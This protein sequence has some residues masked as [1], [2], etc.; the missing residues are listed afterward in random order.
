MHNWRRR[1][2]I[3]GSSSQRP[4]L[5]AEWTAAIGMRRGRSCRAF[6]RSW[7]RRACLRRG[8]LLTWR[9]R[10]GPGPLSRVGTRADAQTGPCCLERMGAALDAGCFRSAS[11]NPSPGS[12]PS[13]AGSRR[14][15]SHPSHLG[16]AHSH[17]SH[18]GGRAPARAHTQPLEMCAAPPQIHPFQSS[19]ERRMAPW[20]GRFP[21][22]FK[23]AALQGC[24]ARIDTGTTLQTSQS[25]SKM[26]SFRPTATAVA[27]R[28]PQGDPHQRAAPSP[29]GGCASAC[30]H[31]GPSRRACSGI[32]IQRTGDAPTADSSPGFRPGYSRP[33]RVEPARGMTGPS[34]A[35]PRHGRPEL[36]RASTHAHHSCGRRFRS[37]LMRPAHLAA[38]PPSAP[39]TSHGQEP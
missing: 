3:K 8:C 16:R 9:A 24:G 1:E 15:H 14:A 35:G 4:P 2:P 19:Q 36:M 32:L 30:Q 37:A 39:H 22:C 29:N 20:T 6:K 34:R 7:R 25:E 31:S 5:V 38:H 26:T 33:A 23:V 12:L 27:L 10:P 17:P 11:R 21:P 28:H 13:R 18:L